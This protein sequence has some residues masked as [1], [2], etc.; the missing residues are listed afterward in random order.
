MRFL[1]ILFLLIF[2]KIYV[3]QEDEKRI[4]GGSPASN[5]EFPWMVSIRFSLFSSVTHLCGGAILSDIFVLT[6][7]NCFPPLILLPNLYSIKAG[8]HDIS[9]EDQTI[10]QIRPVSQI[11]K[12][13][14]HSAV[15]Y[16]NNLALVR[17]SPP[18]DMQASSV[19]TISLSNLTLLENIDL[20]TIG[21]DL[22]TIQ[23]NLS[24]PSPFLQKITIR[25]NV[26]CTK[27]SLNPLTQLCA[28]GTCQSD[29]GG[30]LMI[31]SSD[32]LQYELVA[33]TSFRNSCAIEGLFT[34]TEPFNDW[35]LTTL[36][37]P[38][39]TIQS[40]ITFPTFPIL[41]VPTPKPDVLGPQI[42]FPCNVNYPCGCSRI[43]VVFHDEPP[44]PYPR[45]R[46]QARI[47][48]GEDAQ[49]HSWPWMVQLR[50]YNSHFCG[51]AL[52]NEQWVV[53]AAHCLGDANS[54]T[55]HI[56]VHNE[57]STS[58]QVRTVSQLIP[59]EDYQ[60]PP[61]YVN[62]ILLIRLSSPVDLTVE[63]N[64]ARRTCL[65]PKTA[66]L[67]YPQINTRLAVIG[68]GRLL[69]GGARPQVLRQ[70][71]VKTI[72]INDSR[73]LGSINDQERQFC[74]MVDGGER[75]SCQGD[76]GGPIHQWLGDH[77]EQVGIV[78]FGK[79]CAD[80]QNPDPRIT[81]ISFD[82]FTESICITTPISDDDD[83]KELMLSSSQTNIDHDLFTPHDH[84]AL[85][86]QPILGARSRKKDK[87][88]SK[89]NNYQS[90]YNNSPL[91][92]SPIN[93]VE[94]SSY[95]KKIN[96]HESSD[97]GR[98][99]FFS[100]NSSIQ[101][102]Q[103]PYTTI[104]RTLN[105]LNED[106]N[107]HDTFYDQPIQYSFVNL[108]RNRSQENLINHNT[109]DQEHCSNLF[110]HKQKQMNKKSND[111]SHFD[112]LKEFHQQTNINKIEFNHLSNQQYR[113]LHDL[114]NKSLR[115]THTLNQ[116]S[117]IPI[118]KQLRN[119]KKLNMIVESSTSSIPFNDEQIYSTMKTSNSSNN[120][121]IS[122]SNRSTNEQI[123]SKATTLRSHYPNQEQIREHINRSVIERQYPSYLSILQRKDVIQQTIPL[124]TSSSKVNNHLFR[125]E[126]QSMTSSN[127]QRND[128]SPSTMKNLHIG[129]SHQTKQTLPSLYNEEIINDF[130]EKRN[131]KETKRSN[132]INQW[133]RN[134]QKEQ[135]QNNGRISISFKIFQN[136][137]K[138]FSS[139]PV[140]DI[141]N[142]LKTNQNHDNS[143][144]QIENFFTSTPH[145]HHYEHI[146]DYNNNR[147][148]LIENNFYSHETN[149]KIKHDQSN[150]TILKG[151][152]NNNNINRQQ[153]QSIQSKSV[154]F[155]MQNKNRTINPNIEF[156][157]EYSSRNTSSPFQSHSNKVIRMPNNHYQTQQFNSRQNSP[158]E[159][160]NNLLQTTRI[161]TM[162]INNIQ[163]ETEIN[164][165]NNTSK[166]NLTEFNQTQK[167][168]NRTF[169]IRSPTSWSIV[170][171]HQ[172]NQQQQ[173]QQQQY[174]LYE[175]SSSFSLSHE[176]IDDKSTRTHPLIATDA[177]QPFH[178]RYVS[179][180]DKSQHPSFIVY[181]SGTSSCQ[182]YQFTNTSDSDNIKNDVV[183]TSPHELTES[184]NIVYQQSSLFS[185]LDCLS[186]NDGFSLS[187]EKV[188]NSVQKDDTPIHDDSDD[189]WS[190]D[191]AELIYIDDRYVT[192][193]EKI[194]SS[195]FS[196]LISK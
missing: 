176:L 170:S 159:S 31:R 177:Q 1:S 20:V 30:P 106:S 152:K 194:N 61:R 185:S 9:N 188:T 153:Q 140:K 109:Y 46:G 40:F 183:E 80:P 142:L 89:T 19:S 41:T 126:K 129:S 13:P 77:W 84:L 47:V 14:D 132:N 49:P 171:D 167:N 105:T 115:T 69:S 166:M 50:R 67:D 114:T 103:Q 52:V 180:D 78:S 192:Q 169:K 173:Q 147:R 53:T 113:S 151:R 130:Q 143:S 149:N 160:M 43:P 65:P 45:Y 128:L 133:Q 29:I 121:T 70:V 175:S 136:S 58:P 191:S 86:T 179:P 16:L 56:G 124:N 23:S 34:R 51:G 38:P 27:N 75:D 92:I 174:D 85:I 186:P 12:H 18:F 181:S 144:N 99:L 108:E 93:Q 182:T 54:V 6:A 32:N 156:E 163:Q 168:S 107:R 148:R 97:S 146:S 63:E 42:P 73:C 2:I 28:T 71:R 72:A 55:I 64:Y 195:S 127:I 83:T 4:F 22:L 21:W 79:G 5:N 111:I 112:T 76:S 164:R 119:E 190:N 3:C 117:T 123:K 60:G 62:D 184:D 141:E 91:L 33:I 44:F 95:E 165:F 110:S 66:G 139:F 122:H 100:T 94:Q 193:N 157:F 98:D 154:G 138:K 82:N 158:I 24:T 104:H 48:G 116:K 90:S 10:A 25:E 68:W 96:H 59:H 35:I 81:N 57:T 137:N 15:N 172:I 155:I 11:I 161:Q 189:D 150:S 88:D 36:Q 102:S 74:A 87:I 134:S 196:H 120:Q 125:Q 135:I 178:E 145:H 118:L 39:T 17:V 187:L 162:N 7:A 101:Y 131:P 8:T 26:P 37:N